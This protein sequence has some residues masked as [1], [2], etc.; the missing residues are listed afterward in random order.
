M[1]SKW[2][3]KRSFCLK[4][5]NLQEIFIRRTPRI[6]NLF[7]SLAMSHFRDCRGSHNVA[8]MLTLN[9]TPVPS[10]RFAADTLPP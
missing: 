4:N 10:S 2:D 1:P 3:A 5:R 7:D 6:V 8:Q 9:L